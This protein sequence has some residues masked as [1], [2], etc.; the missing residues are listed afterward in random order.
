M[1]AV[2]ADACRCWMLQH[3]WTRGRMHAVTMPTSPT[4]I[5]HP[6][7][8]AASVLIAHSIPTTECAVTASAGASPMAYETLNA[9]GVRN[10]RARWVA[11]FGGAEWTN[12]PWPTDSTHRLRPSAEVTRAGLGV[13]IV[14][15]C[16]ARI[17]RSATVARP[18]LSVATPAAAVR[19]RERKRSPTAATG[20]GNGS[21]ST[22]RNLD[23]VST[24]ATHLV[25]GPRDCIPT[26]LLEKLRVELT[27]RNRYEQRS[28]E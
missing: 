1:H 24:L 2:R 27:R 8:F 7:S 12:V 14:W 15:P 4:R 9:I 22:H 6:G 10:T 19:T 23:Q 13:G 16:R 5:F 11:L 21:G 25:Y 17:R 3:T 28:S 26:E 20:G 18:D